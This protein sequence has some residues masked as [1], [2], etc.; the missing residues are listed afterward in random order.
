MNRTKRIKKMLVRL[1]QEIIK[2]KNQQDLTPIVEKIGKREQPN[3]KRRLGDYLVSKFEFRYNVLTGMTEY[4]EIGQNEEI[5]QV[6]NERERNTLF[7]SI[8]EKGIRCTFSELLRYLDSSYIKEYHPFRKYLQDLPDWDHCDRISELASRVS[9]HPIWIKGFHRW[10]LGLTAQWMGLNGIHANSVA[11]ILISTQQGMMKSTFC[12]SL[13]PNCL[14]DYYTDQIELSAQGNFEKKMALMG[15]INMDEFDRIPAHRMAQLKNLMQTTTLTIRQAYRKNLRQLPRIASFI[16]TS[17]RQDILTDPS[18]NRRFLCVEVKQK[19][20]CAKIDIHQIYAQLKAE[21]TAGER[22][23]FTSE[24][25]QE[26]QEHNATFRQVRPEEELLQRRYRAPL[27]EEKYEMLSLIE[28]VEELRTNNNHLLQR[29]DF[30]Q[31]GIF[32]QAI[33]LEKIHTRSGNRYKVVRIQ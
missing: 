13:I 15:L 24:E 7:L 4:R 19:I 32:L 27:P 9:N 21:L 14:Q 16:G 22:Y 25:E 29:C 18:G 10:M 17:N 8:K 1:D 20:D 5:F 31:F 6:L 12:K 28:I 26:I 11:P 3:E 33:G 23:W 30:R 2:V